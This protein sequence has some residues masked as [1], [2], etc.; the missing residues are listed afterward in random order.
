MAEQKLDLLK[1][2]AGFVAQTGACA[3][4]VM[5]SNILQ[6]TFRAS[7]LNQASDYLRT[8]SA[9]PN[10]LGLI[11]GPKY[12]AHGDAR[13]GHPVVHRGFDP[14]WDWNRP[15]VVALPDHVGD[16]PMLFALVQVFDR[17]PGHLCPSKTTSQENRN[18]SVVTFAAQTGLVEDAKETAALCRSQ[19]VADPH[20]M[21]FNSLHPPDSCRQI[22]TEQ[23]TI[24]SLVRKAADSR[25]A[26]VDGGRCIITLFE[27]NAVSSNDG[28]V[29]SKSRF[30]AV[31]VDEFADR[32]IIRPL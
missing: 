9:V 8:E 1:L 28:F 15:H 11:D 22:R 18:Y 21:L 23:P 29:E 16:H 19:P 6:A 25:Q 26:E 12:R 24:G 14:G 5:R 30:R 3:P 27:A 10:A 17:Q 20:T 7:G 32:V 13:G 31:P 2:T 4:Q